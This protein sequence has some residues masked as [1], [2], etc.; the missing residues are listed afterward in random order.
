MFGSQVVFTIITAPYR[1]YNIGIAY[2]AAHKTY[3][4]FHIFFTSNQ[5]CS[6]EGIMACSQFELAFISSSELDFEVKKWIK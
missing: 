3:Y 2:L 5:T 4:L 6:I 1:S